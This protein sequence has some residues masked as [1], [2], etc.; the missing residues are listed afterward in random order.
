LLTG[1]AELAQGCLDLGLSISI[2]GVVTFKNA[3]NLRAIVKSIP[4][5]RLLVE[6][7]SPF[8][9]PVPHRGKKNTPAYVRDV[10]LQVAALKG[11]TLEQLAAQTTEN[12][13]KFFP[14]CKTRIRDLKPIKRYAGCLKLSL[15]KESPCLKNYVL[16]SMDLAVLVV[17]LCA[18]A[19]TINK[20]SL[21]H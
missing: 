21:R 17:L 8:L 19:Y 12:A 9:A 5:S 11:M 6:T 15:T 2:S 3:E 13:S 7:D 4:P 14:K 1:S 10:A 20:S 18:R 16:E